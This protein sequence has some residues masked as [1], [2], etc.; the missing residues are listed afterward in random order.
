MAIQ[1]DPLQPVTPVDYT[2]P[3]VKEPKALLGP[4]KGAVDYLDPKTDTVEGRV[5]GIL[6]SGGDLNKQTQQNALNI[7]NSRGLLN[8]RGTAQAG[9]SAL[10]GK[11]IDIAA[12]DAATYSSFGKNNQLTENQGLINNQA[13]SLQSQQAENEGAISGALASQQQGGA[14]RQAG[15]EGQI[16][17][18]LA[19]QQAQIYQN[20]AEQKGQI[21]KDYKEFASVFDNE[22]AQMGIDSAERLNAANAISQ[23]TVT[24]MNNIGSLLNNPDIVMGDNVPTWMSDYMY[25]SWQTTASLYGLDIEVV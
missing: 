21:A 11:A 23:Q 19:E 5:Q 22:L 25:E 17:G 8:S 1:Y 24:M 12:P 3:V 15:I 7:G 13:A 20:L 6:S 9:T 10:I 14:Q 18:G 16:Q 2:P 4:T